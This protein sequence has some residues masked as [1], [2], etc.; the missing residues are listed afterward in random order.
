M[1]KPGN[2]PGGTVD[3]ITMKFDANG[4][5]YVGGAIETMDG[6]TPPDSLATWNGSSW[7]P[8]DI[9]LPGHATV[10]AIEIDNAQNIYIGIWNYRALV[11]H[12]ALPV[13]VPAVGSA[14]A[15]PVIN[16]RGPGTVIRLKNY[17]TGKGIFF[18]DLTFTGGD[19]AVLNLDPTNLS[20][21][22][23]Y[24]GNMLGQHSSRLGFIVFASAR[25]QQHIRLHVRIN[26]RQYR[27]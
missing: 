2:G 5:L 19:T 18:K 17:T 24:R 21:Y 14:T 13:T 11:R 3:I 4:L 8:I 27:D 9:N 12:T 20:F 7:A 16:F 22:G 25:K 23:P 10:Y 1:V 26:G 15:Y 6:N